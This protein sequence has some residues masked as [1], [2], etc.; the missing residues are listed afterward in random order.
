M[1]DSLYDISYKV[2]MTNYLERHLYDISYRTS[3]ADYP[4]RHFVRYID[5]LSP[6][7]TKTKS[8]GTAHLYCYGGP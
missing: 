4:E 5:Q 8:R 6:T 2:S 3:A 7:K 1:H